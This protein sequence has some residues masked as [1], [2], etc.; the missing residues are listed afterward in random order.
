MRFSHFTPYSQ[1]FTTYIRT[2][3]IISHNIC[4]KCQHRYVQCWM[5]LMEIHWFA[6]GYYLR[7]DTGSWSRSAIL[8]GIFCPSICLYKLLMWPDH[9]WNLTTEECNSVAM[10]ESVHGEAMV[11]FMPR[12]SFT[13]NPSEIMP[14]WTWD[15]TGRH[16]YSDHWP[17]LRYREN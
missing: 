17:L 2:R 8:Y 15:A 6:V 12:A 9:F 11:N 13:N 5:S 10:L 7:P 1:N 16:F 14:R 4:Q 3:D